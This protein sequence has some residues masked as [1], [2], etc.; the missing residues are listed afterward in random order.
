VFNTPD[1]NAHLFI[2]ADIFLRRPPYLR[3]QRKWLPPQPSQCPSNRKNS[4]C[5]N[6]PQPFNPVLQRGVSDSTVYSP[7]SDASTSELD[8]DDQYG[9]N[10]L[11]ALK[12]IEVMKSDTKER[13]MDIMKWRRLNRIR[14]GSVENSVIGSYV[15]LILFIGDST[16]IH[17]AARVPNLNSLAQLVVI[18][19]L[20]FLFRYLRQYLQLNLMQITLV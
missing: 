13:K 7:A 3:Y 6:N 10:E 2:A 20:Y 1:V 5:V 14:Q 12:E 16:H 9:A 11:A 8:D 18:T 4:F 19:I 15:C 17:Y